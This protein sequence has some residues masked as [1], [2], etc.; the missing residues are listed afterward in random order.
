MTD[1]KAHGHST[2]QSNNWENRETLSLMHEGTCIRMLILS[3]VQKTVSNLNA[4]KKGKIIQKI[5]NNL[6]KKRTFK[7]NK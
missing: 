7:I 2:E 6:S 3:L 5:E 1:H 4:H